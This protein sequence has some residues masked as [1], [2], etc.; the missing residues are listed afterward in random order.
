[1][2]KKICSIL[3]TMILI[4]LTLVAAALV[5]PKI[6]GYEQ[7]AVLS[8]SMEP[9]IPVGA[10]VYTKAAAGDSLK[11]GDIITYEITG[12]TR[13]THRIVSIDE[14]EGT[15]VTKGDAN[16]A[17]DASPVRFENIR[18]VYVFD[19]PYLGY[20]SIYGKTP[21][22]IGVICGIVVIVILLNFLPDALSGEE[23]KKKDSKKK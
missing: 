13:V 2:F 4:V 3:S 12:N 21:L 11:A 19:I 1:M 10:I 8:G 16:D 5:I 23:E 20:I 22:G 9:E 7:Y 14:A 18:G 17:E 15:V 6:L